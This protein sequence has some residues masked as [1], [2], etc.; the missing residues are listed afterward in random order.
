M[1]NTAVLV[2]LLLLC[3][4]SVVRGKVSIDIE[5]VSSGSRPTDL[6]L[7]IRNIGD[8][9]V[10]GLYLYVDNELKQRQ[11]LYLSPGRAVKM[12]LFVNFGRHNITVA[13]PEGAEDSIEIEVSEV[14]KQSTTTTTTTTTSTS[15]TTTSL[16]VEQSQGGFDYVPIL[17]LLGVA[18]VIAWFVIEKLR[19]R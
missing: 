3:A 8:E 7:T 19:K 10:K 14:L 6:Y 5:G 17:L 2:L 9:P 16:P 4:G 13:T 11:N 1:R 12:Y 18:I 15:T